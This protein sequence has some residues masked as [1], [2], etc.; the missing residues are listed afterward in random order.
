M[1]ILTVIQRLKDQCAL[2]DNRAEPAKSLIGLSDSEIQYDLPTAFVLPLKEQ[3]GPSQLMGSTSQM[4]MK[5]FAVIV[6]ATTSSTNQEFLEDVREQIAAALE[7]WQPD[8]SHDYI[9][10]VEGEMIDMNARVTYWR[11]TFETWTLS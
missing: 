10:H 9:N 6:A 3:S 4:K 5:R 1:R 2:L 7:G 8:A 11:D